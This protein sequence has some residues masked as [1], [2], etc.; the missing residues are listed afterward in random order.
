LGESGLLR[1]VRECPIA[2]IMVEDVFPIV[3][4]EQIVMSIVVI[5][6]DANA[7][8]PPRVSQAG[9]LCNI[10][11]SSVTIVV[12]KAVGRTRFSRRN[13]SKQSAV[14]NKGINPTIVVVVVKRNPRTVCFK[15]VPF[16]P[17]SP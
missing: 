13:P 11:K 3:S 17:S 4:Q 5:V 12:I 16:S 1:Y 10:S 14:W 9:L 2:I 15:D 8:A 6:T 7:I